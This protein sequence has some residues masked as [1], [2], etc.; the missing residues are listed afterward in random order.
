MEFPSEPAAPLASKRVYIHNPGTE[1]HL[2][3]AIE[4]SSLEYALPDMRAQRG[5]LG[6][7]RQTW[8]RVLVIIALFAAT[9][10]PNLRRLLLKTNPINGDDNWRHGL[11][12]PLVGLYYLFVHRE[13]L[14]KAHPR[15]FVWGRFM[16]S[17]RFAAA[18]MIGVVGGLVLLTSFH[19]T[20]LIFSLIKPVGYAAV[21]TAALVALLDWSL[22]SILLGLGVYVW[23]IYPGQ[24]DYL[25]DLGMVITLFGVVLLLNGPAVMKIAWF[26]IAF[27]I[28]AIPW[29]GLVY[30]WVAEP[31]QHMAAVVA[32]DV[33]KLTGVESFCDGT[34]IIIYNTPPM[35]QRVLN[36]AEACAGMR[37][38]MT[39]ISVAATIAFLSARPLWQKIVIVVS[40]VPIAIFCNMARISGQ[41][42]LDHYVSPKWSESYAHQFVGT[43]MLL[44][45]FFLILAVGY[46]LDKLFI[47][48]TD[49]DV[50]G[51]R[52]LR[53][54]AATSGGVKAGLVPAAAASFASPAP[55][56]AAVSGVPVAAQTPA[57]KPVVVAAAPAAAPKPAA[58]AV[59]PKPVVAAPGSP[60]P[61]AA[62][63][64]PPRAPAPVPPRPVTAPNPVTSGL[65]PRPAT[66]GPAMRMPPP[67]AGSVLRKPVDPAK[68]PARPPATPPT[69][70]PPAPPAPPAQQSAKPRE[71]K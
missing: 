5:F 53:P 52:P 50:E 35:P 43:M 64:A 45:A 66:A 29:P 47:E 7:D 25:K 55:K 13:D 33:L 15:Q 26:P 60:T 6:I 63:P 46:I 20:G 48:E 34:K 1:S 8:M 16:R 31:L 71:P 32:V 21:A 17:G 36:V 38:L 51:N 18:L 57:A 65:P 27:L 70:V 2:S 30:S 3:T 67:P 49:G 11:F 58:P 44:P 56:V 12:V 41:G 19:G 40:A 10:W 39:F 69:R 37:S 22:A 23:G 68:A 14:I 4:S 24:N 42:L 59:A 9:F 61:A 62:K 54:V 28:C